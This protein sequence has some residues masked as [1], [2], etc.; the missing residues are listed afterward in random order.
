MIA[1]SIKPD[2][3]MLIFQ[4]KTPSIEAASIP[5]SLPYGITILADGVDPVLE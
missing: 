3:N 4:Q 5:E 2:V 1:I